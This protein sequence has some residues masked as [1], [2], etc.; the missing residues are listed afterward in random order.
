[1][2]PNYVPLP[3]AALAGA[4]ASAVMG[5]LLAGADTALTSLSSTRLEALIDQA[6]GA[7][8]SAYAVEPPRPT[9]ARLDA[10]MDA[11]PV[12]NEAGP[13]VEPLLLGQVGE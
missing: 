1:M 5:A 4:L 7:Q 10:A 2:S 11:D 9:P 13:H 3:W 8:K 6:E 12:R